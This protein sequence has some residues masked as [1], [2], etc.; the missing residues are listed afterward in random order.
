MQILGI[1]QKSYLGI[2]ECI[3]AFVKYGSVS[4]RNHRRPFSQPK[5]YRRPVELFKGEYFK[6]NSVQKQL[7][8]Q[9]FLQE[10]S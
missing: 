1:A 2:S 10:E 6:V 7:G 9:S 8:C 3:H 5:N 4:W